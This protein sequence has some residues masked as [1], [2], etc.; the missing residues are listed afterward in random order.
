MPC[1]SIVLLLLL[2]APQHNADKAAVITVLK[3]FHDA[4]SKADGTRYFQH[5]TSDAVFLG[6]DA[7]ERWSKTEFLAKY[8]PYMAAGKG[9]TFTPVTQFVSFSENGQIAWFDESLRSEHYGVCRGSGV[10]IQQAAV[11]KIAQYNLSIPIPNSLATPFV[12]IIKTVAN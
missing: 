3:S 5:L 4:A 11:W 7:S 10:L 12:E 8:G 6:T 9:W 2:P 1:L